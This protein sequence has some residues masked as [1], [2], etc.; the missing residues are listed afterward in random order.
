MRERCGLLRRLS[1]LV[2]L[3]AVSLQAQS[4]LKEYVRLG[5]RVVA[6][7]NQTLTITSSPNLYATVNVAYSATLMA[8]GGS[9]PY[10][11]SVS[12]GS[13]LP[14][15][16]SLSSSGA[17]SGT[18]TVTGSS[19]FSVTVVDSTGLLST[20]EQFTITTGNPIPISPASLPGVVL[21]GGT[22]SQTLTATS[23][24]A[25]FSWALKAGSN[26]LPAGLSLSTTAGT[27][28]GTPSGPAGTASFTVTVTDSHGNTGQQAFTLVVANKLMVP[29]PAQSLPVASAPSGSTTFSYSAT[30]QASGGATPLTWSITG[31]SLPTGLT[32]SSS[33][34]ISGQCQASAGN[35]PFTVQV[36]DSLTPSGQVATEMLSIMV[37]APLT[38]TT[39]PTLTGG[40]VGRSYSTTLAASGGTT[41]YTWSVATGSSLPP[42]LSLS[43]GGTIS[44]T[45]TQSGTFGFVISVVDSSTP[46]HG[47][48][49]TFSITIAPGLTIQTTSLPGA[50]AGSAYSAP[51]LAATGGTMPYTWSLY[52]G[53]FPSGLTLSSSGVISGTPVNTG[54]PGTVGYNFTV[55]VSD[56]GNPVL[57]TTQALSISVTSPVTSISIVSS[58]FPYASGGPTS[59]SPVTLAASYNG[60]YQT[61]NWTL[62]VQ[63]A[64]LYGSGTMTTNNP[65]YAQY[66][67]P[68]A[69]VDDEVATI[70][71]TYAGLQGSAALP[72]STAPPVVTASGT[73]LSGSTTSMT[74]DQTISMS[75]TAGLGDNWASTNDYIQL[76]LRPS[77]GGS[78]YCAV[79]YN[80]ATRT[81]YLQN[82]AGTAFASGTIGSAGALTVPEC[83]VGLNGSATTAPG[84]PY[85]L[86]LTLPI[87][88]NSS[89]P[90]QQAF[91]MWVVPA[92]VDASVFP[93]QFSAGYISMTPT[94][95]SLTATGTQQFTATVTGQSNSAVTW[96]INPQVGTISSTGLYTAPATIAASQTV[97]V[98][99]ISQAN[100]ALSAWGTV[101]LSTSTPTNLVLPNMT[102]SSGT[103]SFKALQTITA[104]SGF[105]V[106]GTASVTFTAGQRIVIG[107]CTTVSPCF[108]ATAAPGGASTVFNAVINPN[109]Q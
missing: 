102:I 21:N 1:V 41:P 28:S 52:G 48:S 78:T 72:L 25:P 37:L 19:Q 85:L 11:W 58:G 75:V 15:W 38:I 6:I 12:P 61:A 14:A 46:Q 109:V 86:T 9:T 88:F 62:S 80:P 56:S 27:I 16:L 93:V 104:A 23:G 64:G 105:T 53:N 36:V 95:A 81:V 103:S 55:K 108:T 7:E 70:T 3:A 8:T 39:G 35:Y 98:T 65:P 87:T 68:L 94:S 44:G 42:G 59:E 49:Q 91:S 83:T 22:Y 89:M 4:S 79:Q 5:G 26:P 50:T 73:T 17:L 2:C 101:T 18:P 40:I 90:T 97:T 30:L 76:Y 24:T 43:T 51:S 106:N 32:L 107:P 57:S 96:S 63:S 82:D 13:S 20:A 100:A 84:S 69:V 47:G 31:G 10:T 29:N 54:N 60:Y 92:S 45:P 34:V 67:S 71:A 77:G 33:G 74:M 66:T 99:A